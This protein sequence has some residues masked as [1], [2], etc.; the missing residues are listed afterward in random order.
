MIDLDRIEYLANKAY[1]GE[2]KKRDEQGFPSIYIDGMSNFIECD[3]EDEADYIIA[4]QPKVI[5]EMIKRIRELEMGSKILQ[6]NWTK[7]H[8]WEHV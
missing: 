8:N 7:S 5:R 4:V 3:Y 2:W 6:E 1:E